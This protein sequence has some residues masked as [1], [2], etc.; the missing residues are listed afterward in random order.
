[1]KNLRKIIAVFFA[2]MVICSS[3]SVAGFA[4]GGK[5]F[6]LVFV[7]D[8]TGSMGDD[9][10]NVKRDVNQIVSEIVE[11][12][13]DY[14][15]AVIDYRDY[16]ERTGYSGDYVYKTQLDFTTDADEFLSVVDGLNVAGGGDT[17]ETVYSALID[18]VSSLS[19][20]SGAGKAVIL[21]GDAPALDPEP[22]TGYTADDA[23]AYLNSGRRELIEKK[24]GSS[25]DSVEPQAVSK[26]A[27]TLFAINT[28]SSS[29]TTD[30]FE[31]LA[32]GTNGKYY[33]TS[34]ELSSSEIILKIIEEIPEVVEEPSPSFW[35]RIKALFRKIWYILTLRWDEI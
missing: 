34:S 24:Y 7:I 27:I 33:E 25:T 8:T 29:K 22:Y 5:K 20:R 13:Q 11:Q 3:M 6:D 18:G 35:D 21:M 32:T 26:S 10:Y 16:P 14:R 19:W 4:A 31:Y 12:D 30:C 17:P 2:A 28:G 1:M 23:L 9:I 15:L